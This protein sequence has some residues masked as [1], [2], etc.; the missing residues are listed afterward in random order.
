MT[1]DISAWMALF[2]ARLTETFPE[3]VAFLGLQG[4]RSRGEETEDSDI[5]VVVV[6]DSLSSEDI[7]RYR[8]MIDTLPD[9]ELICGFLAG[10]DELVCWEPS[11]LFQFCRD[12]T[13]VIGS[14]ETLLE[15][16]TP[17]DVTRAVRIGACNIYHGCVHTLC[18][19]RSMEHLA[20]LYKSAVF[21]LQA[22]HFRRTGVYLRQRSELLN[23]LDGS[24]ARIIETAMEMRKGQ[25][26]P[27]EP[28]AERLFLWAQETVKASAESPAPLWNRLETA[29]FTLLYDTRDTALARK[30]S[31]RADATFDRVT[32]DFS[33]TPP[34]ATFD[35]YLCPDVSTFM[36]CAG[37][38]PETYE[39]WMVGNADYEN[40]RLC[41]LSPRVVTD[42]PP[43][44]M[45]QV[46]THEI[47]HIA[48]DALCPGDECP[49]WLGEGIATLY[50]GQ[51]YPAADGPVPHIADWTDEMAF[52]NGGG[53]DYAGAYV[54]YFIKKYGLERFKLAYSGG[55]TDGLLYPGFEEEAVAA[56][57]QRL[58]KGNPVD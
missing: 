3:R 57:Q 34:D 12:T 49:V 44:A 54:W 16:V 42:R 31:R 1:T 2:Q 30:I 29:H 7:R 14:L 21:V 47:V 50:A 6:L 23:A 48:M 9:R 35:F 39:T 32:Q 26:I 24:D 58:I 19:G 36:A 4:S 56:W 27:F 40:R 38:T 53:Y 11:D 5:D 13:P 37:K 8:A 10:K 15:N 41:V 52:A 25:E 45:D 43:Q 17:E 28:A 22:L 51:V 20:G 33:I 46:I 18:H 55:K